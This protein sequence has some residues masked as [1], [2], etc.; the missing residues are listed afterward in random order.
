MREFWVAGYGERGNGK[1]SSDVTLHR[2]VLPKKIAF[3]IVL[4]TR[5]EG[6]DI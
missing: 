2:L 1:P 5:R 6:L 4:L 3:G